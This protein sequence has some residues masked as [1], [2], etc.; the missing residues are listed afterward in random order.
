MAGTL[1]RL[2]SHPSDPAPE[3]ATEED[4]QHKASDDAVHDLGAEFLQRIFDH[5][6]L[7]PGLTPEQTEDLIHV[8]SGSRGRSAIT[9]TTPTAPSTSRRAHRHE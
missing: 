1:R 4:R 8:V 3:G 5:S 2:A 9:R 6:V 7:V